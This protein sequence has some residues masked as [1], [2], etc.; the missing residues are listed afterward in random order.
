[1]RL[2]RTT[3]RV[4]GASFI[5]MIRLASDSPGLQPSLLYWTQVT[6]LQ[7][8]GGIRTQNFDVD[9]FLLHGAFTLPRGRAESYAYAIPSEA[10]ADGEIVLSFNRLAGPNAA[11][12]ESLSL[13]PSQ[14]PER[15]VPVL[16]RQ[17]WM[18]Q[19]SVRQ[20]V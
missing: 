3:H 14:P 17:N 11:V 20:F 19:Q 15:I 9:G 13:K 2:T 7:E 1:M 12:S 4:K 16:N 18:I 6:Y 10:Y 8:K 5:I